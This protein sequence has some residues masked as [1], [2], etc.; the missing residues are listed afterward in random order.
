[1]L[2]TE[3]QAILKIKTNKIIL[4][5]TFCLSLTFN[6]LHGQVKC[7]N[8]KGDK[9][10][11]WTEIMP[12]A[13][14]PL[15]ELEAMLNREIKVSDYSVPLNNMIYLSITINCR[16]EAFDYKSM[17]PLDEKLQE[18]LIE[19]VKANM[20]W[21]PGSQNGRNVDVATMISIKIENGKFNNQNKKEIK[22]GKRN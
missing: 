15:D 8:T 16:G 22:K 19:I 11:T 14:I 20:T 17:R 9:I 6:V 7:D 2:K 5:A 18:K 12:K 13:N 1:M 10:Y 21:Q 4:L 3:H